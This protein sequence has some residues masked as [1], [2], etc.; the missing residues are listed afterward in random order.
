M[1]FQVCFEL[2]TGEYRWKFENTLCKDSI[3]FAVGYNF[4][5]HILSEEDH[6][7][8]SVPFGKEENKS[9]FDF[10]NDFGCG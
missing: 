2:G 4:Q 5:K 10:L 7:L 9:G 3:P 8:L 1:F 6:D